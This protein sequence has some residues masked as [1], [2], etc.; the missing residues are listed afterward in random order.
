MDIL[1]SNIDD[2]LQRLSDLPDP[3]LAEMEERAADKGFP[4]VGP[5]VGRV[6]YQLARLGGAARIL[7]LGSGFGYSAYWFGKALGPEGQIT[8]TEFSIQNIELAK[9]F[10]ARG[11]FQCSFDYRVGNALQILE[12]S[13]GPYDIIFNDV[14]KHQ[15]PAVFGPAAARL[16]SGGLLITDNVLW[17][18]RVLDADPDKD[19]RGV[20][21]YTRLIFESPD[22]FSSILP[23]RDGVSVSLKK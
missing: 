15:Y 17:S 2:Y 1:N 6:L 20:L 22:F 5:Q 8:L 16:R 3:A 9:A 4:I 11:R 23:I 7:E 21:E 13:E 18:G 19:T 10:L 14:D 12:A